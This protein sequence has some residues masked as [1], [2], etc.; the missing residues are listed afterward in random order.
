MNSL[1]QMIEMFERVR[2]RNTPV[3][4]DHFKRTI[5]SNIILNGEFQLL[6]GLFD[7]FDVPA[8]TSVKGRIALYELLGTQDER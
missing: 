1:E 3:Y 7:H 2:K 8:A 4:Y 5:L 6:E